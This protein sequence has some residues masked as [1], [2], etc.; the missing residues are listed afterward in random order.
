ML[1]AF[2]LEIYLSYPKLHPTPIQLPSDPWLYY[3]YIHSLFHHHNFINIHNQRHIA[4]AQS[5]VFTLEKNQQNKEKKFFGLCKLHWQN[6]DSQA[7]LPG[8]INYPNHGN[9]LHLRKQQQ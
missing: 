7:I 2:C 9:R 4:Q 5:M 6:S 1:Q 3:T 8:V